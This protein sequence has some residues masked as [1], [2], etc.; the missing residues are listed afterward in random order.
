[1]DDFSS[2]EI[3]R[4]PLEKIILKIKV[5]DCGEPEK[6]LGRAIQPP[7]IRHID[8]A[9]NNLQNYGALTLGTS[10]SVSGEL[11]ELGKVYSEM[12][13]DIKYSRLI[14][15]SYAFDML[16]PAIITASILSQEKN[17]FR[18]GIPSAFLYPIKSHFAAGT[19]SDM[20]LCYN[21]YKDWEIQFG[22]KLQRSVFDRKIFKSRFHE[23]SE[24]EWCKK[25]YLDPHILRE[26]MA[27]NADI[28]IRLH[29]LQLF[30]EKSANNID[31]SLETNRTLFKFALAGAFY[32]KYV[33]CQL[34]DIEKIRKL[35]NN[36]TIKHKI[37]QS[38]TIRGI[39]NNIED[40]VV[41][42]FFKY[43][44]DIEIY[45]RTGEDVLIQFDDNYKSSI[46]K[47]LH[48]GSNFKMHDDDN[49][50]ALITYDNQRRKINTKMKKPDYPFEIRFYDVFSM[51]HVEA[52]HSSINH[53]VIEDKE[54]EI[55]SL[56]YVAEDYYLK[57]G[58]YLA[59]FLTKMP[60]KP[61]L[62][63]ILMLIF[64]PQA[65]F[66]SNEEQT[67]YESFR[68]VGSEND[69]KFTYLFSSLDV[70]D[71]NSIRGLLNDIISN[72]FK[73]ES[74]INS[75]RQLMIKNI[76][77]L[78]DKKRIKIV[79]NDEWWRLFSLY[80]PDKF[81]EKQISH[82]NKKDPLKEN[83]NE[84]KNE[85]LKNLSIIDKNDFNLGKNS[86]NLM[87]PL[88]K[89]SNDFL[90]MLKKLYISEDYRLF[91]DGGEKLL[92]EERNLF[93]EMRNSIIKKISDTKKLIYLE[94]TEVVCG[95]CKSYICTAKNLSYSD[96]LNFFKM[97]GWV[98]GFVNC[99]LLNDPEAKK[100]VFANCF[101]NEFEFSHIQ[102][103]ISCKQNNHVLGIQIDN[104]FYLTGFSSVK[105][106][107]PTGVYR[108]WEEYY[109]KNNFSELKKEEQEYLK[110][111][112]QLIK[113]S[114]NCDL[115]LSKFYDAEE[116][117]K[118]VDKD[119]Q[120]KRVVAELLEEIF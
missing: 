83:L 107:F 63:L 77:K 96:Q 78:V 42:S 56:F 70:D 118:H 34:N 38:I 84:N 117:L 73:E 12:P 79:S 18:K 66:Y 94:N 33:K 71:I 85:N 8:T 99:H 26:V 6:I 5:W 50:F 113:N 9:I 24:I 62:E 45:K 97:S 115:C 10:K 120:H 103:W 88:D 4:I 36:K 90:P 87:K 46:R 47:I 69:F 61:M 72:K 14:I 48:N 82:K 21:A 101:C 81:K 91:I 58:K 32:G 31:F 3:L 53:V 110:K 89:R 51:N 15:I 28:K 64:A 60:S 25:F 67:Q 7:N 92:E 106:H 30:D 105:L 49:T 22:H 13:I 104:T 57:R 119:N 109:W 19:D 23:K 29:K 11:T 75:K 17:I 102:S 65:T 116:Y 1:M 35:K 52:E 39:P 27:L 16:E 93:N 44:G 43:Y 95:E 54:S 76:K 100:S 80:Y 98:S 111:R 40:E 108:T 41:H 2:P 114:L 20:I 74:E 86:H 37:N 55:T 68:I 112:E 59:K